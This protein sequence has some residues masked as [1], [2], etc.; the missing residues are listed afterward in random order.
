M[1]TRPEADEAAEYYFTYINQ[2]PPG[3]I[4][5][6]LETQ[7]AETVAWL[8]GI[9]DE[10]S[11]H[12]YAPGKWSI[13]EVVGHLNDAERLFASRALWFAR[14]FPDPLP[15]FDQDVAVASSEADARAWPTHIEEFRTIRAATSS[16]FRNLPADAWMRRGTASGKPFTVRA[17][18][19]ICAGH[20]THHT[21]I[22]RARYL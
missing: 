10:R 12:R 6:I 2:V 3:D 9:S 22:V 15:S 11:R 8:S 21:T 5:T 1:S 16:L 14:G 19:W 18:A 17:L 7:G 13:R 20:V 4:C